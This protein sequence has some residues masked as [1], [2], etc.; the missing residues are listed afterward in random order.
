VSNEWVF[1]AWDDFDVVAAKPPAAV[2]DL[3]MLD[4]LREFDPNFLS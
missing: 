4:P 3:H 1:G 2:S